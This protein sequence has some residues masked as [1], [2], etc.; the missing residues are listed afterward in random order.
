[1]VDIVEQLRDISLYIEQQPPVEYEEAAANT[2]RVAAAEIERL[3]K[4]IN[5]QSDAHVK[6]VKA[7]QEKSDCK[8]TAYSLV[9]ENTQQ[10]NKEMVKVL[11][12]ACL[13]IAD[14]Y[15]DDSCALEGEWL[16]KEARPVYENMCDVL[17]KARE[18]GYGSD[19]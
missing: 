1:M 7:R 12:Q 6:H 4:I 16:A 10:L 13:F 18:A 11:K 2:L 19:V 14:Q 9:L 5:G 17:A 3:R 15:A 8:L